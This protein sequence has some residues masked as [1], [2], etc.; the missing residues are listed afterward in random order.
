VE[1]GAVFFHEWRDNSSPYRIG[2]SIWIDGAGKMTAGGKELLTV[3]LSQWV[4]VRIEC[5]MGRKADGT[6][7]LEVT[8]PGGAPQTIDLRMVNDQFR[9]LE[10]FGF[11]S[12]A[13]AATTIYVDDVKLETK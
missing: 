6:Y 8:L 13:D 12:N 9:R 2:P 10:W 11:V 1:P 3:P 7:K 4:G 5:G